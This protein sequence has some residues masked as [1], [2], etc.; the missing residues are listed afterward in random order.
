MIARMIVLV[1]VEVVWHRKIDHE[2][3]S[4][5]F[6]F[7]KIHLDCR[8]WIDIGGLFQMGFDFGPTV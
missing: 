5:R 8:T 3:P 6:F 2:A 7:D 4:W 1:V